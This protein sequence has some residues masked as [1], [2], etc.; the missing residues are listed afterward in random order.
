MPA[1]NDC[2]EPD[3]EAVSGPAGA[4][5]DENCQRGGGLNRAP[6]GAGLWPRMPV[7]CTPAVAV[8]EHVITQAETLDL[9][10]LLH[11]DHPQIRLVLR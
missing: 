10:R 6:W 5:W 1:A 2:G 11:A 9:A 3:G 4:G 8:P 7:L